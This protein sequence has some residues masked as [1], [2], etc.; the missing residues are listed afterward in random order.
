MKDL[1]PSPLTKIRRTVVVLILVAPLSA[2]G[3]H[4]DL[5]WNE[6]RHPS[7]RAGG[8][9]EYR[10]APCGDD[11]LGAAVLIG[12]V[13]IAWGIGELFEAIGGR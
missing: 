9:S 2:C 12:I 11:A 8:Y 7:R 13:G 1:T 4:W 5:S 10:S 6:S 3:S